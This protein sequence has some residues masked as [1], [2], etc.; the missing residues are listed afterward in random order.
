MRSTTKTRKMVESTNLHVCLTGTVSLIGKRYANHTRSGQIIQNSFHQVLL[1]VS[2]LSA[3][4][5][6]RTPQIRPLALRIMSAATHGNIM[7]RNHLEQ[8]VTP[9]E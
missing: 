2:F 1:V 3:S 4:E 6:A 8:P 9:A 7:K 5:R